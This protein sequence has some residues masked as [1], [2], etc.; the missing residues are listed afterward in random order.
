MVS[1]KNVI[2]KDKDKPVIEDTSRKLD[3]KVKI[4]S[5]PDAIQEG[6]WIVPEGGEVIIERYRAGSKPSKSICVVKKVDD[7]N[8]DTWDA[9]LEQWF[10]FSV[11]DALKAGIVIKI[12]K[13]DK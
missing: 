9:T 5:L 12:L 4:T 7:I 1:R 2:E 10:N 3:K 13:G 11:P 6:K 8:I